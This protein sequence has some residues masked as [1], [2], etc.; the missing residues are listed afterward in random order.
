MLAASQ[1]QPGARFNWL[2]MVSHWYP[3]NSG[4]N[5]CSRKAVLEVLMNFMTAS[6]PLIF[7]FNFQTRLSEKWGVLTIAFLAYG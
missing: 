1:R 2:M 3:G 7:F 5:V 4:G 6:L